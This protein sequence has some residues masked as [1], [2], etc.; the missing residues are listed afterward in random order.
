MLIS[1]L[2]QKTKPTQHSVRGLR[3]L[4]LTPNLLACRSTMVSLI[5]QVFFL[6]VFV[7]RFWVYPYLE[8]I[9]DMQELD[10]N[11]KEKLS[12]FCHVPVT[13]WDAIYSTEFTYIPIC[14]FPKWLLL[15][16]LAV[17]EHSDSLWCPQHLAYSLALAGLYSSL[18][19]KFIFVF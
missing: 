4:G 7:A 19:L 16:L 11:V 18:L 3:S 2:V 17:R 1:F 13:W 6:E 9:M 12:R 10:V 14:W 8:I 15:S 5:S